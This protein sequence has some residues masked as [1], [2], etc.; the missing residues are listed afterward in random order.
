MTLLIEDQIRTVLQTVKFPGFSRDIVSFGLV[1]SI[2]I[3]GKNDVTV[4]LQIATRE[5]N[6][7]AQIETAVTAA[8]R[9]C[10]GIGQ[11]KVQLAVETPAAA[12]SQTA[13]GIPGVKKIIA[14]AS[15]KGGVG[16]ST[17]S[18]NLAVALQQL[19]QSVGLLDADIY[20]PS[21]PKMMGMTEKPT[22]TDDKLDPVEKFGLKMMSMALLI[23]GDAPII[24]R[25][26]MIMKA[27]QQ[28][29]HAVNWG[30]LDVLV[31]DLPPGTGDA[32]LTLTQKVPIT[33][34]IIVS[35]PQD[36][37]LADVKK[38]INMFRKVDVAILGV[39]ENMSY[40]LC[41]SCGHRSEIFSHGGA[42][43]EAVAGGM[44]FLGHIPLDTTIC[45]NADAGTP[46][47]VALPDSPQTAIY[48]K[49]ASK[50]AAQVATRQFDSK[51]FPAIVVE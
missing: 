5:P 2:A 48:R 10:A 32:Q 12:P 17:V 6:L 40:F 28:F 21:I 18:V 26:P 47:V 11:I 50:V 3:T 51:P 39:I 41:P 7:P 16:K 1:K 19:G 23:E 31:V 15:G 42:L 27:I 33:G 24:W 20:G 29:S 22:V 8:L 49:I 30:A 25:G 14:V 38:A 36:V 4:A 13:P 45:E 34:V 46:I 43:R 9:Q 37:A 44:V 35:T